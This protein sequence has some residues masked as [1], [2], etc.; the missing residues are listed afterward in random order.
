MNTSVSYAV[1]PEFSVPERMSLELSGYLRERIDRLIRRYYCE[2]PE[3]SPAIL[4]VM[5]DRDKTPVR[6][7]LMPW[8]GEFAGKYLTGAQLAWRLTGDSTLKT[9]IDGFAHDLVACQGPDGYLGPFNKD[10]RLTGSNWDVWGH[11]HCIL[12]LLLYYE[13]TGWEP[14]LEACK[15]AGDLLFETFGPGG[16]SLTCDGSGGQ[17]NMAICHGMMLLYMKTGVQRY[18]DLAKYVVHDAW[19]EANA[20]Q[21]MKSALE[22]KKIIEFPQHRW[23]AIHDW[24]ALADLYWLTGEED[25]R[26]TFEHIYQD[27]VQGDRH[28]TGGV[29]A[30]EGFTGSPYAQGAIE[31]CCTVAWIA[32]T[33]D[34]LRLTGD[35]RAADE[36]EWS[37]YNSALGAIPYS[38][39]VCAY[40]VPMDGTRCFGVELPWQSPKAGPDLNC[41]AVNAG[42]PL[43]MIAQWALMQD[44][45]GNPVVNYYGAGQMK[46]ALPSGGKLQL[47]QVTSYPVEPEVKITVKLDKS[48]S[49]ALKLRIPFWSKV[50]YVKLNDRVLENP[51]EAGKY[52]S[53]ERMWSDGDVIEITMDFALR[54][55]KGEQECAGKFSAYR[56]PLL[57]A[58]D[59]RFSDT[60]PGQI[61]PMQTEGLSFDRQD[62]NG[63]IAPWMFGSLKDTT[64]A[65]IPVCDFSSAGQT[66]NHYRSWLPLN[67]KADAADGK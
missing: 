64:G 16:P 4:Q 26:K 38:G 36:M 50:T 19:N 32:Y 51:V 31:T 48:A 43:G 47:T 12:G 46:T 54:T 37:T 41:C 22:G 65:R 6:D 34:M 59:A 3:S 52:L 33:F 15:K 53:I 62:Y 13:D 61:A 25:Y 45:D 56:G 23:E 1:K 30:G 5:R 28:N 40:N 63:A 49:F 21:Y 9:V 20:G 42:R 8:A 55:W 10:T 14:A 27:G 57:L 35:S 18:L 39:R 17:M 24:Q 60:D 29:T 2:T 58:F 11:Y 67:E 44:R 66:G 7:P